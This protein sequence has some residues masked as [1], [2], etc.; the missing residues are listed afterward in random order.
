MSTGINNKSQKVKYFF[1]MTFY[2]SLSIDKI[3]GW[4]GIKYNKKSFYL[5]LPLKIITVHLA[6]Y[7]MLECLKLLNEC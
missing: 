3:Q 7:I 5:V 2:H 1:F 4:E 6:F